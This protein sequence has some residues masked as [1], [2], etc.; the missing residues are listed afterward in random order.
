MLFSER[1][2]IMDDK[3]IGDVRLDFS[4]YKAEDNYFI[5]SICQFRW[6]GRYKFISAQ[7]AFSG[8]QSP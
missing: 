7:R 3:Y 2:V 1:E 6:K 5:F 4:A 8:L